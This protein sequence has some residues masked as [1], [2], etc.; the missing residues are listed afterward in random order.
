[1][2]FPPRYEILEANLFATAAP[3]D[4][5]DLGVEVMAQVCST[6]SIADHFRVTLGGSKILDVSAPLAN[7][8]Q[9]VLP[10]WQFR[11]Q[12]W[13]RDIEIRR[14]MVSTPWLNVRS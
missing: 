4:P 14:N 7:M 10:T 6:G 1:M 8:I 3:R 11:F 12:V 9:G 2:E 5:G 13:A